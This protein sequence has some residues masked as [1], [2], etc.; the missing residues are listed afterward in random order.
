MTSTY[1]VTFTTSSAFYIVFRL[2]GLSGTGIN[3][4]LA[5]P[6]INPTGNLGDYSIRLSSSGLIGTPANLGG[7]QDLGNATYWVNGSF[8]PNYPL[9]AYYVNAYAI[10]GTTQPALAGTSTM[11]LSSSFGSRFLTGNIAEVLYYP[12]GLTTFQRQQVE[13]YLAWK[14][15]LAEKLPTAHPFYKFSPAYADSSIVARGGTVKTVGNTTYS[16]FLAFTSNFVVM[17]GTGVVNYLVVG[18]GGGGGDRHGG[19][20]GAGGV[21]SGRFTATVGTYSITV[22]GGGQGGNYEGNNSSPRGSGLK[23]GDSSISGPGITTVTAY[24]GGGGGTYDGNPGGTFG[25]GGGGGGANRPG[26][27]GTA[28]QGNAGGSGLDPGGGGGGGAGTAGS[29]ANTSRGGDGTPK[30]SYRL[31]SVQY[32]TAIGVRYG[33]AAAVTNSGVAYIAAGGGGAGSYNGSTPE[34]GTG[35]GG[36]GDWNNAYITEGVSNT[37]SGGGG[38]RSANE[39]SFGYAGGAGLVLLWY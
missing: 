32:G 16:Y 4:V 8:N 31:L 33:N 6:D 26:I 14:W 21:V 36:L 2:T 13:G 34:G 29:N 27:A 38:S 5:F 1:S 35:G 18:G 39:P 20:G 9:N 23:G 24:G 12:A 28:G 11:T 19:G 37:G 3:S 30:Y 17:S 15:G 22:G 7:V 25:S 10:V